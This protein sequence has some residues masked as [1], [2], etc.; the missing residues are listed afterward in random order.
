M[1]HHS[2][3]VHR[4][5]RLFAAATSIMAIFAA[6]QTT[7]TEVPEDVSA[8]KLFQL[9]QEAVDNEDFNEALAYYEAALERYEDDPEVATT[10]RYE[11]GF[12]HYRQGRTDEARPYFEQVL[13]TYEEGEDGISE[14]PRVLAGRMLDDMGQTVDEDLVPELDEEPEEVDP[15]MDPAP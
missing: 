11:I 8:P 12:V 10:A 3:R 2:A 1:K 14:W 5:L 15:E 9:A 7:P 6:C 13:E 4:S